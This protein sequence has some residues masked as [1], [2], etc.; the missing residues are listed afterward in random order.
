MTGWAEPQTRR[1]TFSTGRTAELDVS[2]PLMWL[3]DQARGRGDVEAAS[4]F[5]MFVSAGATEENFADLLVLMQREIIEH[6][7][8]RPR[9]VYD[10]AD[11]P[12]PVPT[13]DGEPLWV[14][15]RA[16]SDAEI[17]ETVGLVM[18]EIQKAATFPG[19]GDRPAGRGDSA[20][21][22]KKPKPRSRAKAGES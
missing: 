22:G 13:E 21:V 7:F 6:A 16:L 11:L 14:S 12:S 10:P 15:V 9:V 17:V 5:G 19:D 8:R 3:A 1:H 4:A 20:G 18:E 2:L